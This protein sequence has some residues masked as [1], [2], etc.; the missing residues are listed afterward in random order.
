MVVTIYIVL[1]CDTLNDIKTVVTRII[2]PAAIVVRRL[3]LP[4]S[5]GH[6][7]KVALYYTN[8]LIIVSHR[9]S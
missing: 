5:I 2:K 9:P 1:D 4:T 7:I 3:V 6:C 8:F